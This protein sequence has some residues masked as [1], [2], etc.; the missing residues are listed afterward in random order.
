MIETVYYRAGLSLRL[1]FLKIEYEHYTP[2]ER[3]R[4]KFSRFKHIDIPY[5]KTIS[6][7]LVAAKPDGINCNVLYIEDKRKFEN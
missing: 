6:A 5:C 1:P 3:L 7:E 2:S 4:Q